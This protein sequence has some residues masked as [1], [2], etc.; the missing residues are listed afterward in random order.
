MKSRMKLSLLLPLISTS[1]AGCGGESEEGWVSLQV[2]NSRAPSGVAALSVGPTTSND[3]IHVNQFKVTITGPGIETPILVT[4]DAS[5]TQIQALGIP[6]GVDRSILIEAFNK[7]GM[8]I[9]RR[10]IE[11]IEIVPGVV[12]PVKTS[13]HTIPLILNLRPDSAVLSKNLK[14]VGFGEPGTSI[15]VD[16][17]T[18]SESVPLSRSAGLTSLVVS[19]AVSTGLFEFRPPVTL[20][21]KQTITLTDEASGEASSMSVYV[22]RGGMRPGY[23]LNTAVAHRPVVSVGT[24][25]GG[26]KSVHYPRILRKLATEPGKEKP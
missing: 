2:Q 9:R 5:A 14:I 1:I 13:L 3:L 16:A 23:R 17:A 20:L 8:V 19:P 7:E 18:S 25:L 10:K 22:V 24:G 21:G 15:R 12:T 6:T 26:P 4:A 11:R